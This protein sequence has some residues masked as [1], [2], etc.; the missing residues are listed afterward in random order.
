MVLFP[1]AVA[2][3]RS[4][5]WSGSSH[6]PSP[7]ETEQGTG[8]R[9]PPGFSYRVRPNASHLVYCRPRRDDDRTRKVVCPHGEHTLISTVERQRDRKEIP[10]KRQSITQTAP[11]L[12]I[13]GDTV[14]I[15]TPGGKGKSVQCSRAQDT[16]SLSANPCGL[17]VEMTPVSPPPVLICAPRYGPFHLSPP[18]VFFRLCTA[19]QRP[20]GRRCPRNH[21]TNSLLFVGNPGISN[22]GE[23][24]ATAGVTAKK[25]GMTRGANEGARSLG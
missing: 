25:G 12:F 9:A 20:M 14:T 17:V 21:P 2:G 19:P 18:A 6:R 4:V 16:G 13:Q 1:T 5:L 3:L 10:C 23:G 11:S 8:R 7:S 22:G 15:L 24:P